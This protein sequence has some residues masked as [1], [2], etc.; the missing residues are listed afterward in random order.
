MEQPVFVPVPGDLDRLLRSV[1]PVDADAAT[2]RRILANFDD[3]L[4]GPADRVLIAALYVSGGDL[5][6]LRDAIGVANRDPRDVIAAAE[7]DA[8]RR[9]PHDASEDER[10]AAIVLDHERYRRWLGR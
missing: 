5:G 8:Y 10:H 7:Y 9:L 4:D 2:A 3:P 6:A 1:F